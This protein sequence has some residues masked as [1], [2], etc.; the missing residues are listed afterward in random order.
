MQN[1]DINPTLFK[2]AINL[3]V[4]NTTRIKIYCKLT[5]DLQETKGHNR[6]AVCLLDFS[7][8]ILDRILQGWQRK[9]RNMGL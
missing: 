5:E 7:S 6:V 2:A 1:V 4:M 3:Y 9:S 8:F